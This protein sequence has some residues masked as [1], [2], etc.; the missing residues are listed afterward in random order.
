MRKIKSLDYI[1]VIKYILIFTLFLCLN[2]LEKEVYPYSTSLYSSFLA[3]GGNFIST[4][5][6]YLLSF[7][8]IGRPGLLA[9]GGIVFASFLLITLIRFK[10]KSKKGYEYVLYTAISL[11]GFI[12]LGDTEIQTAIEKRIMCLLV[13]TILTLIFISTLSALKNKGLKYKMNVEEYASIIVSILTLGVCICNITSP[14][15]WR[16]I[17]VFVILLSVYLLKTGVGV[18]I[19]SCL[20]FSLSIYYG[21]VNF[22]GTFVVLGLIAEGF[23][24]FSRYLSAIGIVFFDYFINSMFLV[25]DSYGA[26]EIISIAIPSLLFIIL[27]S[28]ILLNYKEKLLT[29]RERALIKKTINNQ[30]VLL[31]NKL[32]EL[33]GVFTEMS[34]AFNSFKK[35]ESSTESI[36]NSA[37]KT[38]NESVCKNC[39]NYNKCAKNEREKVLGINKMI[40]IGFAKGKLSLIDLPEEIGSLCIHPADIIYSSNKFLAEYRSYRITTMNLSNSRAI[41]AKE[42]E[43][44]AEILKGLALESGTQLKYQSKLEKTL[45][46]ELLKKGFLVSEILIYGEGAKCTVSLVL[47]MKEFSLYSLQNI[48][49]KVINLNVILCEKNNITED[50]IY[51]SFRKRV[52]YD[53]VFGVSKVNK[54]GSTI[55]GDTHSVLRISDKKFLVA[56]SDGMGS[57]KEAENVSS[58]SLSLIESFYKAGMNSD[59]ILNTVNKLLSINNEDSFTALDVSVIDLENRSADF[60]KYGAPYGF[61][62]NDGAVKIIEGNTLPLG[63]LEDLSPSVARTEVF[64][65]DMI[66]LL[67]DGISDAFKSSSS[68]IDFLRSV[69]A[70]N[71]QTLANQILSKAIALNEGK[72]L[73]DMTALAVRIFKNN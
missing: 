58:I 64:D 13:S 4:S 3:I 46:D 20:G 40:D 71:P 30:R 23:C 34:S 55:S 29:F 32:F 52:E 49:S 56:L 59:L 69:P 38:I 21:N 44:V 17:A 73:D 72:H 2:K 70:K 47:N 18:T 35:C 39:E 66:L 60:I 5:I 12:F 42:A 54:D 62:I 65:G 7:I 9:S 16:S 15:V 45:Y 61:I 53:A 24:P 11:V 51:L 50:K 22:V 25:Y 31:S 10:F 26:L 41:M 28:K 8:I 19:S 14:Y 33:S 43:G 27:P 6:I 57:G 67:T 37:V 48:I 68:I 63:I 1:N 36:K